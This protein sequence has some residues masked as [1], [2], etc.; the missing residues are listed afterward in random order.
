MYLVERIEN[1]SE[2]V[3]TEELDTEMSSHE[4]SELDIF[5]IP[6]EFWQVNPTKVG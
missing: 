3:K 4:E 5:M 2:K 1:D 6:E